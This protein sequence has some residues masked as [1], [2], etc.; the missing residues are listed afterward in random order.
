MSTTADGAASRDS[1]QACPSTHGTTSQVSEY[2]IEPPESAANAATAP[3]GVV[4]RRMPLSEAVRRCTVHW[5]NTALLEAQVRNWLH[6]LHHSNKKRRLFMPTLPGSE[7]DR[8]CLR[9]APNSQLCSAFFLEN[10][11]AHE[12]WGGQRAANLSGEQREGKSPCVHLVAMAG[13]MSTNATPLRQ[14]QVLGTCWCTIV[15]ALR[16]Y[17]DSNNLS[18]CTK[19]V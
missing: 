19:S 6:A 8:I 18:A 1:R 12:R 17:S 3:P 11:R 16:C 5:F 15:I 4:D 9:L 14:S 10:A 7:V 2:H 13:S